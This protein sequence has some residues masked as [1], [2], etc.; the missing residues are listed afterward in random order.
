[1]VLYKKMKKIAKENWFWDE[2]S[3]KYK[4]NPTKQEL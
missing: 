4:P 1:V 2:Q 3:K